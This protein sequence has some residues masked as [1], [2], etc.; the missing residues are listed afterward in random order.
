MVCGGRLTLGDQY[1]RQST[2]EFSQ[3]GGRSSLSGL[4]PPFFCFPPQPTR[5]SLPLKNALQM[6]ADRGQEVTELTFRGFSAQIRI[7][8]RPLTIYKPDYDEET[9][10]ASG[11]IAS[12]PGKEY[13]VCWK[14][15]DVTEY[16]AAGEVY[17][18]GPRQRSDGLAHGSITS[19]KISK[20]ERTAADKERPFIFSNLTTTG[21]TPRYCDWHRHRR[22]SSPRFPRPQMMTPPSTKTSRLNLARSPPRFTES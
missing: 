2:N 8:D 19:W 20:G 21:G 22:H 7:G 16:C 4:D 18:D 9:K 17:I 15:N 10:T 5:Q 12:E 3:N 11:W 6:P 14:K 13:A 1:C